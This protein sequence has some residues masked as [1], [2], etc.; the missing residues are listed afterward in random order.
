MD[1]YQLYEAAM[2]VVPV[3]LIALFVD[4]RSKQRGTASRGAQIYALVQEQLTAVLAFLAFFVSMFV[5]SG[6]IEHSRWT[7][8]AV[9]AGLAGASILLFSLVWRRL[10]PWPK[11]ERRKQAAAHPDGSAADERTGE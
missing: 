11:K 2:Q 1:E 9:V 7:N 6:A 8:A 4:N 3:L 10:G 5:L